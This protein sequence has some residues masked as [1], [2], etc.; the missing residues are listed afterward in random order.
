MP[1]AKG[2]VRL[3]AERLC[4]E[5][6]D[7]PSRT[8]AKKLSASHKVTIEL[9][10]TSIRIARGNSGEKHRRGCTSPRENQPA[11][12]T[13][14][15]PPSL[16]EPWLPFDLG[17]NIKVAILSDIHIPYH[18][19]IAFEA[20]VKYCKRRGP[21]VLLLNG[22]FADFYTISRHQKD[23]SKRDFRGEMKAC[24]QALQWLRSEFGKRCRIVLKAGNHEERLEHWVWNSAPEI[25]DSP[26]MTLRQWMTTDEDTGRPV[27]GEIDVVVDQRPVMVGHLPVLHGHELGKAGIAAPVNPARGAFMRSLSTMLV[28]HSHRSSHHVETDIWHKQT[29]CWSTGALCDL[30]PCYAKINKWQHGAAFVEVDRSGEFQVQNFRIGPCG[31]IWM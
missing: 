2:P 6:P 25:S 29:S 28:G 4:R 5:F 1:R 22:D 3:E 8:L 24:Q 10:R 27:A 14:E 26:R 18:S 13:P 30:N 15:M 7:T 23:P 17:N 20:A 21:D 12:W 19:T 11:G 9:A 31:Q 16:A